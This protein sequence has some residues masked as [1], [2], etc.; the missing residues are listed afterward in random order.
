MTTILETPRL[1][2][3]P[4]QIED[5][6]DVFAMFGDP[7]VTRHL[8]DRLKHTSRAETETWLHDMVER[9]DPSNPLGFWATVERASGHVIGG[10]ALM[11][12]PI[13]GGN[14]IEIGYSFA[15]S[16]WG[17]GYA[18]ELGHALLRYG[19]DTLQIAQ[20]VAVIDT[21]NHASR[22]VLQKIGMRSEGMGD[23]DGHPVEVFVTP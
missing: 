7:D 13:N 19:F 1:I 2:V 22:R 3:R 10:A 23:Y 5:L 12:A 20:I 21:D 8:P 6:H 11:H 9:Y 18:T 4:W 14:P 16:A 15:R 17:N